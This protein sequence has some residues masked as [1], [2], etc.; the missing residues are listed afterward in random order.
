MT[1]V[2]AGAPSAGARQ[3]NSVNWAKVKAFVNRMQ[4][5]IAKAMRLRKRNKA[6]A[7]QRLLSRSFYGRLWAVKRVVSNK[8]SRSRNAIELVSMV[9]CGTLHS[10]AGMLYN[11]S[12]SAVI[13]HNRCAVFISPNPTARNGRWVFPPCTTGRCR[14]FSPKALRSDCARLLKPRRIV[15]RTGFERSAACTMQL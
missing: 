5:R 15:I 2:T 1:A 10:H 3:W 14:E 11:S 7:L 8:G 4:M 9:W 13:A 6:K 12:K